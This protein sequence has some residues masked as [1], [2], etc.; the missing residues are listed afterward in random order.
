MRTKTYLFIAATALASA[1]LVS[2]QK[3]ASPPSDPHVQPAQVVNGVRSVPAYPVL[4]PEMPAGPNKDIYLANCVTC[5]SQLYVLTQ[6]PFTRKVWTAEVDKM[7]K[8]YGAPID[9]ANM[10]KIV[11]YLVAVHGP[12]PSG[13]EK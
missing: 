8:S 1:A 6:P 12:A 4:W 7:K 10:P 11:D 13:Q 3:D 2:A 9:D 5:H